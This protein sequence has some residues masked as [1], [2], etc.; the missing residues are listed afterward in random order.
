ML[1]PEHYEHDKAPPSLR[2]GVQAGHYRSESLH[3][4]EDL[5]DLI[6]GQGLVV[7]LTL[8]IHALADHQ[9]RTERVRFVHETQTIDDVLVGVGSVEPVDALVV[10]HDLDTVTA[11]S[12]THLTL[13]TN[14]EV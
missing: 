14:R 7:G 2:D 4:S 5:G 12:Y 8:V 6:I 3:G 11:V 13:P 9:H 10:G 1:P